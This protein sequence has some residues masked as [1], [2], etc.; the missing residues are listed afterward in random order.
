MSHRRFLVLLV[1]LA[2]LT[3]GA[4]LLGEWVRVAALVAIGA[5]GLWGFVRVEVAKLQ[6]VRALDGQPERETTRVM[7]ALENVAERVELAERLGAPLPAVTLRGGRERF[8]YPDAVRQ[9]AWWMMWASAAFAALVVAL[10][11][12]TD[13]ATTADLLAWLAL[14]AAFAAGALLMRRWLAG[15]HAVVEVT[16]DA[17]LLHQAGGRTTTLPWPAVTAVRERSLLQSFT[18][19]A[20]GE[21]VTVWQ[22]LDGYGR[23][24]NIAA[25]RVPEGARWSAT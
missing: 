24:V 22:S 18:L 12:T 23:L 7:H 21:R 16:D 14:A 9:Q 25:T 10:G 8:G 20:G 2:A 19:H 3:V 6:F 15:T 17:L 4:R 11:A 1:A 13:F 5:A